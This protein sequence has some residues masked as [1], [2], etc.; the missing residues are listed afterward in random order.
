[1]A[2]LTGISWT[3]H[4]WNPWR[5]CHK[6][7]PG[8]KNCYMFRDQTRWGK[9]PN[10]VVR[11]KTW[12]QPIKLQ[13]EAAKKGVR[14]MV[15][16]CSWSDFFIKEADQWRDDA[17][18]IIKQCPNLI[19]QVLTKRPERI[20]KHLPEDWDDGYKNVALGVSVEN[21]NYLDRMDVLRDIPAS[22]RFLSAEP[23]I[24][25]LTGINLAGFG[26]VITGGESGKNHRYMDPTWAVQVRDACK[27]LSIPFFHKQGSHLLPGQDRTLEG[28]FYEEW[29]E[30]WLP[31]AES[32]TNKVVEALV[33]T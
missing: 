28:K 18:K 11:C 6:V 2:E 20:L 8:C 26:W 4:T 22:L 32:Y 14:E 15:F 31:E 17:W 25:P 19:F 23:L 24:G 33:T 30:G 9:D 16:T 3:L 1:M 29:P 10:V 21:S 7:S 5:G 13:K 12:G 27:L